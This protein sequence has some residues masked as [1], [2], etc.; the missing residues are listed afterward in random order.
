[1]QIRSLPVI[2]YETLAQRF[3]SI[4]SHTYHD[5]KGISTL[6]VLPKNGSRLE[7]DIYSFDK[8]VLIS[9]DVL[10]KTKDG[11]AKHVFTSFYNNGLI[12]TIRE[13]NNALKKDI[14]IIIDK[15]IIPLSQI[16]KGRKN[17]L[18]NNVK[19]K[20]TN[21]KVDET[22]PVTI[23]KKTIKLGE[24]EEPKFE[25]NIF[26][27]GQNKDSVRI[28]SNEDTT[29]VIARN[30]KG[31]QVFDVGKIEKPYKKSNLNKIFDWF[32]NEN[33]GFQ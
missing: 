8:D 6:S 29:Y 13:V 2:K 25:Y 17:A 27:N 24:L 16:R 33:N 18:V 7:P 31:E 19:N 28:V 12:T 23:I 5:T 21:K 10:L 15:T 32:I 26:A 14:E 3:E 11:G 1:M 4:I 22:I 30:E 20:I 9:R